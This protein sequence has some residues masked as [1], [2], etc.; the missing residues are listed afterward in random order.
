MYSSAT[1]LQTSLETS[2]CFIAGTLV[3]TADGLRPIEEIEVGDLVLSEDETTGEVAYKCVTKT[4]VNETT[5]LI[6]IHV[7][8]ETISATPAHPFYVDGFGWTLA[9]NL[10]AGDVLVLSNG[11][12]VVVEWVQHEIIE[13]P[14]LVYNFEVEDFHTYF[15]GESG[16]LVHNECKNAWN[17]YQQDHKHDLNPETGKKY[18]R[19]ELA[20][21]YN[22]EKPAKVSSA[23]DSV[24]GNS[25]SSM[26]PQH[27][28]EIYDKKEGGVVKTGISGSVLNQDGSSKRANSQ[29]NKWNAEVGEDRYVANVVINNIPGRE[30]ALRWEYENAQ[31]LF[32]EGQPMN[33]HQLPKRR[34]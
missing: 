25:K 8:G 18:T 9:G 20:A 24:H 17:Q 12:R 28:Y 10:R 2:Y 15:V 30:A 5:E 6:H 32:A 7:G 31:R 27:G 1:G 34:V 22:A 4:F 14:V 13:A 33:R 19:S 23:G 3:T 11:E 26:R 29:V 21:K 16:I